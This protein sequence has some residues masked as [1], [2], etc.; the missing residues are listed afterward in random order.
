MQKVVPSAG[1]SDTQNLLG[2][3]EEAQRRLLETAA[4][5][6]SYSNHPIARSIREA[7]GENTSLDTARVT[8]AKEA[9]GHGIE[10][11]LDGKKLLIGNLSLM[12]SNH[13]DAKP[14]EEPGTIIYT[15][16]S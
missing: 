13:I 9:A 16:I 8:D 15:A 10:A 7:L 5:G 6:E 14:A 3:P 12:T 11:L 4:L 2:T 1:E